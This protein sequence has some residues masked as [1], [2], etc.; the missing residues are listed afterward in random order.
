MNM[1]S[2]LRIRQKVMANILYLAQMDKLEQVIFLRY[3]IMR[4]LFWGVKGRIAEYIIHRF[5]FR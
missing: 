1:G 4:L 2:L 3:V 5:H